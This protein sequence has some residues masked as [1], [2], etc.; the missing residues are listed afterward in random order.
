MKE[1]LIAVVVSIVIAV[2]TLL[3]Y[4]FQTQVTPSRQL[5]AGM[6]GGSGAA[7]THPL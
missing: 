7:V 4:A 1:F 2:V 5:S 3:V 6:T